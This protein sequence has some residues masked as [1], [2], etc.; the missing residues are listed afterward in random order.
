[1]LKAVTLSLTSVPVPRWPKSQQELSLIVSYPDCPSCTGEEGR[2]ILSSQMICRRGGDY[3]EVEDLDN[4]TQ[5]EASGVWA[6]IMDSFKNINFLYSHVHRKYKLFVTKIQLS[7]SARA[8]FLPI[9][10]ELGGAEVGVMRV[11]VVGLGEVSVSN[12]DHWYSSPDQGNKVM[13][14]I[15]YLETE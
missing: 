5:G 9:T 10:S 14:P 1:M 12:L 7:N 11:A 2:N 6:T 3:C 8:G 4:N 13:T 15:L